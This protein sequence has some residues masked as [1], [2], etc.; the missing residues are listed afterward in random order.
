MKKKKVLKIVYDFIFWC[1]S[2]VITKLFMTNVLHMKSFFVELI[3]FLLAV[4]L[5][6]SISLF[7]KYVVKRVR[8]EKAELDI[9]QQLHSLVLLVLIAVVG[10]L[11]IFAKSSCA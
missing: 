8:K 4:V 3:V 11:I 2:L 9:K 10:A 7:V 6:E 5:V 1:I